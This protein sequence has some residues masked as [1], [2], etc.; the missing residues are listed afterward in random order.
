M[1][2]SVSDVRSRLRDTVTSA[3]SHPVQRA[4]VEAGRRAGGIGEVHVRVRQVD[5]HALDRLV[6]ERLDRERP[7][8]GF[9]REIAVRRGDHRAGKRGGERAIPR[10]R[11]RRGRVLQPLVDLVGIDSAGPPADWITSAATA[12]TSGAAALVPKKFGGAVAVDVAAGGRRS[13]RRR[14]RR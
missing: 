3:G 13:C 14:R 2:V 12:A 7:V 9:P 11:D 4:D 6:G 5:G 8:V 10:Q 1:K